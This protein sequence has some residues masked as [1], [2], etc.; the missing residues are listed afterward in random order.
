MAR[1][2]RLRNQMVDVQ[3]ARRGVRDEHVL[4]AMRAVPRE[5]FVIE[6]IA[7]FAYEDS[8]LPIQEGQT[9]SQPYI[10]IEAAQVRP[11]TQAVTPLGPEHHRGVPE[12]YPFGE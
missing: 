7:E 1:Y 9:I 10:M 11:E 12:T 8:A 3:I 4:A 2:D 6:T 5:H